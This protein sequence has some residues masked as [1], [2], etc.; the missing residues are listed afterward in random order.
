MNT[1]VVVIPACSKDLHL[2][3]LMLDWM[4]EMGQPITH[5]CVLSLT[6]DIQPDDVKSLE[7]AVSKVFV[8]WKTHINSDPFA[9][10]P[11]PI[12]HN[13]HFQKTARAVK[14]DLEREPEQFWF[15]IEADCVPMCPDWLPRMELEHAKALRAGKVFTGAFVSPPKPTSTPDHMT[16]NAIYPRDLP[17]HAQTA[18][19]VS[20]TAWDVA[21][22]PEILEQAYFTLAIQHNYEAPTFPDLPS[23]DRR[24][25]TSTLLFHQSKDGSLIARLRERKQLEKIREATVAEPTH[26]NL[27]TI[28]PLIA[29]K[30]KY[31]RSPKVKPAVAKEIWTAYHKGLN[32]QP[33]STMAY[34]AKIHEVSVATITRVVHTPHKFGYKPEK[35]MEA[36]A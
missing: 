20:S 16:G 35:D 18:M 12:P 33:P 21:A 2:A 8:H 29:P 10:Q 9:G 17:R 32:G 26:E 6:R 23:I 27:E 28:A 14:I 1:F 30:K 22:A 11:W 7:S 3:R 4:A 36:V 25:H 5:R 13:N 34:L 31:G 24:V 19:L 15:W